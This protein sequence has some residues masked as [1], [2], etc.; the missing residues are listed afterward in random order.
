VVKSFRIVIAALVIFAAGV[1][2]GGAG[3]V[4]MGR[5]ASAGLASS[6]ATPSAGSRAPGAS[7]AAAAMLARPPGKAQIEAMGRWSQELNLEAG[8]RERIDA[9]LRSGTERLRE[10][11]VPV[12]PRAR[13]EID[14]VR[15]E[16]E[17]ILTPE[18]RRQWNEAR[19]RRATP[20]PPAP[21][22]NPP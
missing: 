4:L 1:L 9:I 11:W 21:S 5:I 3:V 19:R 12:A 14:A 10:L 2:V 7:N 6:M 20:K 16:I 18:Q 15:R 13:G 22:G 8:Q 17:E